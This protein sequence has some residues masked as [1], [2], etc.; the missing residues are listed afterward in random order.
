MY[1]AVLGDREEEGARGTCKEALAKS[2]I[3]TSKLDSAGRGLSDTGALQRMKHRTGIE[4]E[5]LLPLSA[6]P[7]FPLWSPLPPFTVASHFLAVIYPVLP[8]LSLPFPPTLLLPSCA[9]S[10]SLT[11]GRL[12]GSPSMS[13]LTL[14]PF[15]F[16]SW[17]IS[18]S[19]LPYKRP[20]DSRPWWAPGCGNEFA[21]PFMWRS[22]WWLEGVLFE[23]VLPALDCGSQNRRI[24][25]QPWSRPNLDMQTVPMRSR[26]SQTET[27]TIL[28]KK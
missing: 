22:G 4:V 27:H 24:V 10:V 26:V 6:F 25:C 2:P 28:S 8:S 1:V 3:I 9:L 23:W 7:V 20:G 14:S 19:S 15:L 11:P 5:S 17:W 12:D 21:D 16:P 18:P 13:S